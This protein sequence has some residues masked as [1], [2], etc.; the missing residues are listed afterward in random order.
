M[1]RYVIYIY[2]Y[3]Y[4]YIGVCACVCVCTVTAAVKAKIQLHHPNSDDLAFLYGTI[5]TDGKDEFSDQP[6]VNMTI[7]ADQ[8][9]NHNYIILSL[10]FVGHIMAV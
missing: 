5:V 6:T 9:V 1:L 4:I 8:E 10:T 7:F 3:I 2:I